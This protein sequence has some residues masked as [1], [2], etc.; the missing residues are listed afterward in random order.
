[1]IR[2]ILVDHPGNIHC[3]PPPV[4][5]S[6]TEPQTVTQSSDQKFRENP[7][8]PTL[9]RSKFQVQPTKPGKGKTW[10]EFRV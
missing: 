10:G 5:V 1:M 6:L 8:Q 9:T 3:V 7:E 2:S 4:Q